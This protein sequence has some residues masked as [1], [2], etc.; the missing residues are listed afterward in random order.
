[1]PMKSKFVLFTTALL[2]A[3]CSGNDVKQTLGLNHDAPD[4]FRVV[5]RPPLSVPKEFFLSPPQPGEGDFVKEKSDVRA[6]S[7]LTGKTAT[8]L[9]SPQPGLADTAAPVV[10]TSSLPTPAESAILQKA[11]VS[12]ADPTIKQKIYDED[13]A[14]GGD[15]EPDL[16]DRMRGE[17]N[18]DPV[19]DAQGEASRIKE[20]K[21]ADK[22]LNE[23]DVPVV[24]PKK[25]SVIDRV[26]N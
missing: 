22:P 15:S 21:A 6:R 9:D 5:S 3:A 12:A 10:E 23:G 20:N 4:E 2:L 24:D 13:R 16:I 18:A 14:R 1:M 26:F 8:D 7:M 19:V 17:T 25:R 11:G